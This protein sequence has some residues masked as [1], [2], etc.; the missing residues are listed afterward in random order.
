MLP[1]LACL[2]CLFVL[3]NKINTWQRDSWF[4]LLSL[5]I[6]MYFAK[7]VQTWSETQQSIAYAM[8]YVACIVMAVMA[9]S[10]AMFVAYL[11]L[12]QWLVAGQVAQMMSSTAQGGAYLSIS[13]AVFFLLLPVGYVLYRRLMGL[14]T[15]DNPHWA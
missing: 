3:R 15:L 7:S 13:A 11:L 6:I 4:V 5:Q 9:S 14:G 10:R 2:F 8:C 1:T 12:L